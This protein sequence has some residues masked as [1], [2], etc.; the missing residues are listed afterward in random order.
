MSL[1]LLEKNYRSGNLNCWEIIIKFPNW[2]FP[3]TINI[4]VSLLPPAHA[5]RENHE[6]LILWHIPCLHS[7]IQR[8]FVNHQLTLTWINKLDYIYLRG[9]VWCP[10]VDRWCCT[11]QA[12]ESIT[13]YVLWWNTGN[14]VILK[15]VILVLVVFTHFAVQ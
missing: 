11:I 13:A 8:I 9:I 5:W 10:E 3:Q 14:S 7:P 2:Y 15:C 6:F 4:L 12:G 1:E